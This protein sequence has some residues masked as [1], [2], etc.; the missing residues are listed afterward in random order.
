MFIYQNLKNLPKLYFQRQN[1][2]NW[3]PWEPP[4]PLNAIFWYILCSCRPPYD[5]FFKKYHNIGV[6]I[7]IWLFLIQEKYGHLHIFVYAKVRGSIPTA[8]LKISAKMGKKWPNFEN[9]ENT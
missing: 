1:H 5:F 4:I 9:Y 7:T 3:L 8:I 6:S 2:R